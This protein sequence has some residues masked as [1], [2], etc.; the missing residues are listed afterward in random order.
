LRPGQ[1]IEYYADAV[2]KSGAVLHQVRTADLPFSPP[3][4]LPTPL[5][6]W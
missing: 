3:L 5:H 4:S 6:S 1:K 2:G